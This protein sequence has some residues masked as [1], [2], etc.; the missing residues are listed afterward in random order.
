MSETGM[1]E[2]L[3]GAY[4]SRRSSVPAVARI[5]VLLCPAASFGGNFAARG[6]MLGTRTAG[7]PAGH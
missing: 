3:E 6:E 4:D 5:G 7:L 1:G 2:M